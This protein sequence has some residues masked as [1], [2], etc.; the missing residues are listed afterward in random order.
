MPDDHIKDHL[1]RTAP[2]T[3]ISR[4]V[5]LNH[6]FV[7]Y[8][9][10]FEYIAIHFQPFFFGFYIGFDLNY[11]P[12]QLFFAFLS[13]FG[14]DIMRFTFTIGVCG[15]E[16]P[17]IEVVVYHRHTARAGF[18]NFGLVR[19]E[20]GRG[21]ICSCLFLSLRNLGFSTA[22]LAVYLCCRLVFASY[23]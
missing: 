13:S 12:C 4:V 17:F 2:E 10:I 7:L 15:S 20:I 1:H 5:F 11:Q 9:S 8:S 6:F 23:R 19:L 22:Y 21:G 16:P 18:A 3:I 14:I